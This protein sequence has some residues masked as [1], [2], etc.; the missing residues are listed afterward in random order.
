MLAHDEVLVAPVAEEERGN[1]RFVR[2]DDVH[3]Q[4]PEGKVG[5]GAFRGLPEADGLAHGVYF[6]NGG[7]HGIQF[8]IN[9]TALAVPLF[10][11]HP[12]RVAHHAH[13]CQLFRCIIVADISVVVDP[14]G[15][16]GELFG[17]GHIA[18]NHHLHA[19]RAAEHIRILFQDLDYL[20]EFRLRGALEFHHQDHAVLAAGPHFTAVGPESLDDGLYIHAVEGAIRR[21]VFQIVPNKQ[22]SLKQMDIGLDG[23]AVLGI[24]L[25]ERYGAHIVIVGMQDHG[26]LGCGRKRQQ[27][28]QEKQ[29]FFHVGLIIKV[30]DGD[31]GES[32]LARGPPGPEQCLAFIIFQINEPI[33]VQALLQRKAAR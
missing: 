2:V 4:F 15:I 1:R 13:L 6:G 30:F 16:F 8:G 5:G 14:L 28:A 29:Q 23:G 33:R 17:C 9:H 27:A 3:A 12:E 10:G 11:E 25:P 31:A 18:G 26:Q 22:L 19:V 20:R 7:L 21:E 32:L 24:G